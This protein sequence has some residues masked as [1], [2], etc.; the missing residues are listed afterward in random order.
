MTKKERKVQEIAEFYY[1]RHFTDISV[2]YGWC[3][4]EKNNGERIPYGWH[5][6]MASL[7]PQGS[8]KWH[9][10]FLGFSLNKILS[11]YDWQQSLAER[12]AKHD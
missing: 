1:S 11:R 4:L 6:E 10:R 2:Y 9:H 3:G 8:M 7:T 5:C 12:T